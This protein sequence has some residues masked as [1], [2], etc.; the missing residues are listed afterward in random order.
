MSLC[1]SL[2]TLQ[3]SPW[4]ATLYR[5]YLPRV[6]IKSHKTSTKQGSLL[7]C[8]FIR[9]FVRSFVCSFVRSFCSFRRRILH[10]IFTVFLLL[11]RRRFIARLNGNKCVITLNIIYSKEQSVYTLFDMCVPATMTHQNEPYY[12]S[13]VTISVY[14]RVHGD[15]EY[16][17]V[18][19]MIWV[20]WFSLT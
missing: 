7:I 18:I 20:I 4:A 12:L 19:W 5:C 10:F 11:Q 8:S 9:S 1:V 14:T 2:I 15:G 13:C 16:G 6:I 3:L 17:P